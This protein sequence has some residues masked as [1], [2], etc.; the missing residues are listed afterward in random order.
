MRKRAAATTITTSN[1]SPPNA[2]NDTSPLAQRS[3][4]ETPGC[5]VNYN[6][7]RQL[8]IGCAQ[9][10]F[11]EVRPQCNEDGDEG[12]ILECCGFLCGNNILLP[13]LVYSCHGSWVENDT[14]F[15]IARH[16]GSQHGV[17]ISFLPQE[18]TAAKLV[19]GDTCKRGNL[20]QSDHH[21]TANLTVFGK[22]K[23]N[24]SF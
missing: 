13:T 15:I 16:V 21:L 6:S 22:L 1:P 23:L 20:P 24:T 2:V 10:N 5:V 8:L 3:R 12:E 11:V 7:Q 9:P 4:R 19:V 18:G 17:C 14:T